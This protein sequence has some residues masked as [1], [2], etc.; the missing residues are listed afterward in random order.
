MNENRALTLVS[1]SENISSDMTAPR[2]GAIVRRL[3]RQ[4]DW[5]QEQLGRRA[6][7]K[8]AY[9][10]QVESGVRANPSAMVVKKL[11]RALGV[12]VTELLE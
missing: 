3:R 9:I 10:S 11:A 6:G 8:Q 4:R 7:L 5:T 2:L 12:P 1:T